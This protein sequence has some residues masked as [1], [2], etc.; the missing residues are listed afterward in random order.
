M[1]AARHVV[2]NWGVELTRWLHRGLVADHAGM[3]LL[4]APGH[5]TRPGFVRIERR[6]QRMVE[7]ITAEQCADATRVLR[8]MA[9]NMAGPPSSWHRSSS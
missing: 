6:R 8:W 1:N 5:G 2:S 3:L 7:W 9:A 4:P